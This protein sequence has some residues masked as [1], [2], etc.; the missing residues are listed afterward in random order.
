MTTLAQQGERDVQPDVRTWAFVLRAWT[1]SKQPDAAENAQRVLDKMEYR[2]MK[3]LSQI[4]PNFVCYT[5]VMGAWG[6]S[7][8]S[9]ALDKMEQILKRMEDSYEE[10]LEPEIRPN[11]VSYVTVSSGVTHTFT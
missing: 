5:T 11:T 9:N 7:K 4:R 3:G 6:Y 2:Y 8:S 1:R 10:T